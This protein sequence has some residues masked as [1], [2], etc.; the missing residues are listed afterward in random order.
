MRN[1]I[2]D[3]SDEA[4]SLRE[5]FLRG[6]Q[7]AAARVQAAHPKGSLIVRDGKMTHLDARSIIARENG[8]LNWQRFEQQMLDCE[9]ARA[10][11]HL[12]EKAV[13][14]CLK[15]DPTL[16]DREI[17]AMDAKFATPPL[18]YIANVSLYLGHRG[19][20]A[21]VARA[22]LDTGLVEGERLGYAMDQAC[23]LG[24]EA[25]ALVLV[26]AGAPVNQPTI[27]DATALHWAVNNGMPKLVEEL[28]RRGADLEA[29][30][31]HWGGTPLWWAVRPVGTKWIA[32]LGDREASIRKAIELGAD[33]GA[34]SKDGRSVYDVSRKHVD[35]RKLMDEYTDPA[36]G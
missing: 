5:A 20:T 29:R 3:R 21:A 2:R 8:A 31:S 34:T 4:K 22:M 35:M 15:K 9:F 27:Y 1:T 11:E 10:I 17:P 26:D 7:E 23:S 24:A 18:S 32:D 19:A 33:T 12:D 36:S 16:M 14:S 30:C 28:V 13:K 25:V 6:D